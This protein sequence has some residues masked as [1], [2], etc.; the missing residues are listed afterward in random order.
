MAGADGAAVTFTRRELRERLGASEHQV[1][2][3]LAR[4]VALEYLTTVSAGPAGSTHR[5]TVADLPDAT[6]SPAPEPDSDGDTS[7][8]PGEVGPR[9]SHV[10]RPAQT[11]DLA[12]SRASQTHND[13]QPRDVPVDVGAPRRRRTRR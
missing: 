5:Y 11:P 1:R 10:E 7:R 8:G 6:P 3:G 12:T 2:V 4:L 9:G 13:E